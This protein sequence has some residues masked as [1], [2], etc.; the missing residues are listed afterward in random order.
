MLSQ[1]AHNGDKK[2]SHNSLTINNSDI[3]PTKNIFNTA[4]WL[5][6]STQVHSTAVLYKISYNCSVQDLT[7]LHRAVGEQRVGHSCGGRL[8]EIIQPPQNTNTM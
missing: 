3:N 1:F 6:Y 4:L 5:V 8:R 7:Q 2:C